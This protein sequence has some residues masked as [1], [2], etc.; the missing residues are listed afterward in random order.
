[1]LFTIVPLYMVSFV[2]KTFNIMMSDNFWN[3]VE[4]MIAASGMLTLLFFT[5][6]TFLEALDSLINFHKVY[7]AQNID[8]FPIRFC[9]SER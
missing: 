8:R 2:I 6:I 3:I 5:R 4:S 1:M 9:I 7:N